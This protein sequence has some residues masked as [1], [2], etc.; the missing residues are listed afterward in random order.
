MMGSMERAPQQPGRPLI[1][2]QDH[3]EWRIWRRTRILEQQRKRR[4][5]MRRIDY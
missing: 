2:A 3:T 5:Q 1:A 4:K